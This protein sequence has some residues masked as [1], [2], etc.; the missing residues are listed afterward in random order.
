M[1]MYVQLYTYIHTA[2]HVPYISEGPQKNDTL[3]IFLPQ[4]EEMLGGGIDCKY[5]TEIYGEAG[6]GKTQLMFSLAVNAMT[7]DDPGKVVWID[8]EGAFSAERVAEIAQAKGF[9]DSNEILDN[10][11]YMHAPTHE[12]QM[13]APACVYS[14]LADSDAPYKLVVVDSIIATFRAEFNGRGELSG[15]Q[16][17]LGQHLDQWKKLAQNC[18]VA[19]VISNQICADPGNMFVPNA[20]KPVGGNILAHASHTRL[21][22]K[23][24]N[25]KDGKRIV[26]VVKSAKLAQASCDVQLDASGIA[27]YA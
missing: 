7:S 22:I 16:Q 17:K 12:L 27:N 9:E 26:K 1:Y 6:A 21:E 20:Y 23:G 2:V 25:K 24:A 18:G 10:I 15:R 13:N 5:I 4:L 19:V 11:A 3:R 8:T 14:L